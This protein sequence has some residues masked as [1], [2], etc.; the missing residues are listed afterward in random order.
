VSE[1]TASILV[2]EVYVIYA[3]HTEDMLVNF[4]QMAGGQH[5]HRTNIDK[6]HPG[7]FGKCVVSMSH[8]RSI[9]TLYKGRNEVLPQDAE[10]IL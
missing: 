4:V 5:H 7:Y 10:R 8:V 3:K 9:L 2:V 1:S 6:Y